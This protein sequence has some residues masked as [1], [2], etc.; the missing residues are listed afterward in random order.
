M[1]KQ[2]KSAILKVFLGIL[3]LSL[4]NLGAFSRV[5]HNGSGGAFPE[6]DRSTIE[7]Y[8][9]EAA[10]YFLKSNSDALLLAN[11]IEL[12]DIYGVDY[13][14]LQQIISSTIMNMENAK[15]TY[16]ELTRIADNTPYAPTVI[17]K[18]LNFRYSNNLKANRVETYLSAGDVRGLYHKMISDTQGILDQLMFIKSSIDAGTIPET[19]YLWRLNQSYYKTLLFGQ[20]A[21]ETFFHITGK[22][23]E[24][25]IK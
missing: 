3:I 16:T 9:I 11:K 23:M 10:G 17:N 5:I 22:K 18:L 14:E 4:F 7:V 25:G 6:P 1:T 12:S 15:T 24:N 13:S 19:S 21:A 2:T 8:V 20:Q